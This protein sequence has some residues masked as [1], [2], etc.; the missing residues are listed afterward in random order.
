LDEELS[1]T[2]AAPAPVLP[3]TI[4]FNMAPEDVARA[5]IGAELFV[6]NVGGRIVE[7]EAY[8]EADP[9]SHSFR[10]PTP[11][12][13]AMFGPPGCAYIYRSYGLH[14]CLNV[15]CREAGRGAAVLIRALEPLAGIELMRQR[16]GTDEFRLLCAGPGRLGQ[17]L[18]IDVTHDGLPLD[19]SPF[20]LR[21]PDRPYP[22]VSSPRI[23]IAKARDVLWRFEIAGSRYLSRTASQPGETG[24]TFIADVRWHGLKGQ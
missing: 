11:R 7:T 1:R 21:P 9:A 15:V 22:I 6:D 2:G 24:E 14:W 3:C 23:G 20:S 17:T 10:G 12:N 5:L 19:R 4:D 16:R 8:D 13:A 18:G